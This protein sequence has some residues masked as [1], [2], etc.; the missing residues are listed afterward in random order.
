MFRRFRLCAASSV[1]AVGCLGAIAQSASA[2][3]TTDLSWSLNETTKTY[4]NG[5]QFHI[6]QDGDDTAS[7]RWLDS[8]LT[9]TTVISGN[10]CTDYTLI[11]KTTIGPGD[12]SYHTLFLGLTG[13][14]FVLRGRTDSGSTI[15]HNAR[16]RR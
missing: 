5:T 12:T 9:K 6:S 16:L 1:L 4:G 8:D 11:G 7:Y 10:T 15:T 13:E 3:V 2:F 14:C